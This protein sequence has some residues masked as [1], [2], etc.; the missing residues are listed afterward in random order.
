MLHSLQYYGFP[1]W[2]D[3]ISEILNKCDLSHLSNVT[4]LTSSEQNNIVKQVKLTLQQQFIEKWHS[5]ISSLPKLRTYRLF[6]TRFETEKYLF[7]FNKN[8]RHALSRF[9]MSAHTLEIEKGCWHRTKV[10][11]KLHTS[12][13]PI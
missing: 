3:K 5:D 7:L 12:K 10:N 9:R 8:H 11:G 6:K 2:L 13:T 4:S 1:I